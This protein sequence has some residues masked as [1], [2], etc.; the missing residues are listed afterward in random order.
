MPQ[1][2]A[3]LFVNPQFNRRTLLRHKFCKGHRQ[4]QLETMCLACDA[5]LLGSR[6]TQRKP[7]L[8]LQIIRRGSRHFYIAK[9]Q[10]VL[11]AW[12]AAVYRLKKFHG[13]H[14]IFGKFKIQY[15]NYIYQ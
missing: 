12:N 4:D 3:R 14:L 9:I 1:D 8:L 10:I 5:I 2:C 13:K 11:S 15:L 6:A 7:L